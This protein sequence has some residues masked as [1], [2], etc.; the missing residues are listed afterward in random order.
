M[1]K[2]KKLDETIDR[3]KN[4]LGEEYEKEKYIR[5]I[6]FGIRLTPQIKWALTK[7]V[8]LNK[9]NKCKNNLKRLMENIIEDNIDNYVGI[10]KFDPIKEII[11]DFNPC[12]RQTI[13][14][15]FYTMEQALYIKNNSNI[16]AIN[17]LINLILYEYLE[18]VGVLD[19]LD[20]I[21]DLYETK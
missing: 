21:G 12:E 20:R 8:E 9:Q 5:K 10:E 17:R 14:V 7:I 3:L 1:G 18:R 19:E 13:E 6:V 2:R 16:V 11:K 4:F 15:N